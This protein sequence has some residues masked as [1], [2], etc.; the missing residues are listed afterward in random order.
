MV[1][2]GRPLATFACGEDIDDAD[3]DAAEV[4]LVRPLGRLAE[5]SRCEV[6]R[7]RPRLIR[8]LSGSYGK[9][10][11]ENINKQ[12]GKQRTHKW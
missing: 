5:C 1:A 7:F 9:Q 6:V 12:S 10:K 4:D 8:D 3:V 2:L 11:I